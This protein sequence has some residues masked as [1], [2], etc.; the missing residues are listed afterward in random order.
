[1]LPREGVRA[2]RGPKKRLGKKFL[3]RRNTLVRIVH[4][5][6]E[7]NGKLC[8]KFPTSCQ[9]AAELCRRSGE[10]LSSRHVRR[11][12]N[13]LGFKNYKRQPVPTRYGPDI[14]RQRAIFSPLLTKG[15]SFFDKCVF[16]D[17]T[18]LTTNEKPA[19]SM[20]AEC[21]S[22]VLGIERKAKWNVPS[23]LCW[24]AVGVN[25]KS[26]LI[27]FPGFVSVDGDRKPFRLTKEDYIKRCLGRISQAL[28]RQKRIFQ[29]DGAR[30]HDNARVKNYLRQKRIRLLSWAP[31]SPDCNP[32]EFL[33]NDLK[34]RLSDM[35]P[36]SLDELK[37][38]APIAWPRIPQEIIN[39][40]CRRFREML[41]RKCRQPLV[42]D[43][44][45]GTPPPSK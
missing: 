40:H 38:F 8:P 9:I 30:C 28:V 2:M 34:R 12:L 3:Q 18:W 25:F 17:E 29:Q 31:Y 22:N 33:W 14:R 13:R 16:S 11:E 35:M 44:E 43:I 42:M 15:Q 6:T 41:A 39:N 4:A 36:S 23:V 19:K 32:I 27:L 24:A 10:K 7:I 45:N 5:T 37:T 1:M 20:Y 26:P 21:R